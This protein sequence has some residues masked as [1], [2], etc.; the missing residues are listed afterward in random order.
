[1]K[2]IGVATLSMI[3]LPIWMNSSGEKLSI[4]RVSVN[5][6][7]QNTPVTSIRRNNEMR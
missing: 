5:H 1:M 6:V 7:P 2:R 3:T 4:E